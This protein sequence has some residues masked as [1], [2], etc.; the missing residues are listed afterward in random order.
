MNLDPQQVERL[1]QLLQDQP[2]DLPSFR[3]EVSRTGNNYQWL[4]RNLMKRNKNV[5][6]ELKQLLKLS[7]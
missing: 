6:D 3:K 7:D 2:L 4:Q 1:N 5:S